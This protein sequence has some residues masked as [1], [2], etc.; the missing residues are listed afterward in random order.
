ML[1]PLILAVPTGAAELPPALAA[2]IERMTALANQQDLEAYMSF[3]DP[4]FRHEDGLARAQMRQALATLWENYDRLTYTTAVQSWQQSGSQATVVL[5]TRV[6]G[7]ERS[8]RGPW[9]LSGTTVVE[10]RYLL[11]PQGEWRL[12]GQRTLAESITL[13]SG[14]RPPT[15]TLNLPQTVPAGGTYSLEA[16]VAEPLRDR[17]LAGSVLAQPVMPSL[18]GRSTS[19]R[20]APLQAGGIFRTATAPTTPGS[21]WISVM[22]VNSEGVTIT[23]QRLQILE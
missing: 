18:Y 2:T 1:G 6:V 17:L 23:S 10:N 21:Q 3:F 16:I 7:Q 22:F 13:R 12:L 5:E 9:E 20:L 8:P 19:F 4:G 11:N 14:D 15:V